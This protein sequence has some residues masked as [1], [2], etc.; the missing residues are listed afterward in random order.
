LLELFTDDIRDTTEALWNESAERVDVVRRLSYD[1]LVL[2]ET[3]GHAGD[4]PAVET[5]LAEAARRRG[6]RAFV[7]AE[8]V[9]A[10]LARVSF[11]RR[12]APELD[13]PHFDDASVEGA[14]RAL[15][16]GISSFAELRERD[17]AASLRNSLTPKAA[18]QLEELAPPTI[19][20][21]GGRR[22]SID[23]TTTAPSIKSR[24]QDFFGLATG[25]AVAKGR[26][27][28][29]LHLL[30]P[31]QRDVQVTTDLAGF[32]AKHYP[33]LAKE[34][35]RRYPKHSWPEDPR[36]ARPPEPRRPSS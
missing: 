4:S 18:R 14:L 36:A 5:V 17:L 31:N 33:T 29:V 11:I 28:L 10:W 15:C 6:W 1:G 9:E 3:K 27:P 20:L 21:P 35:R 13:I 2:D 26:V 12:V 7:R 19:T 24:I 8:S 25:P 22:L 30:A 23:Y 34:L 16:V 32:W